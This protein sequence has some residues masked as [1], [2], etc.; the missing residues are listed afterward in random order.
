MVWEMR[1]FFDVFS[2]T[3]QAWNNGMG[4]PW[5]PNEGFC[6]GEMLRVSLKKHEK[7]KHVPIVSCMVYLPTFTIEIDQ[8]KV[9]M[10]YMDHVGFGYTWNWIA[11]FEV[12]LDMNFRYRL[13][14]WV[15]SGRV[16][17]TDPIKHLTDCTYMLHVGN[18]YLHFP[19]NVS[20]NQWTLKF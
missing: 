19:L 18:I 13:Y 11:C 9:N 1:A 10:P 17:L 2:S 20:L 5:Q 16:P 8:M 14:F 4:Q 6:K 12:L 7:I 15:S 3:E